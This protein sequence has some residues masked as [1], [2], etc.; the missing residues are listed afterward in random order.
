MSLSNIQ[1]DW[2]EL[3]DKSP[4]PMAL[5]GREGQFLEVNKR[6]CEILEYAKS[7]LLS[8]NFQS[9]TH[10]D[11]LYADN[12]MVQSC[13]ALEVDSYTMAKRYLTKTGKVI[14]VTLYVR[15]IL[16]DAKVAMFLIHTVEIDS[17]KEIISQP[18]EDNI[19]TFVSNN[20]KFFLTALVSGISLLIT[21]LVTIHVSVNKINEMEHNYERLNEIMI[22]IA[23]DKIK[24]SNNE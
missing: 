9:I 22:Q 12:Q 1:V 7:E 10:P 5:V 19:K 17:I 24:E 13:L 8:K 14:W 21:F 3:F 4:I 15:S 16:E 18:C 23:E 2:R 11:D 6:F 20:W